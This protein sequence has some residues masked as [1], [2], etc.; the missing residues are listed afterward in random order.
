[1]KHMSYN[2]GVFLYEDSAD[3]VHVS[4]YDD[5]IFSLQFWKGNSYGREKEV[6]AEVISDMRANG[7]YRLRK[8]GRDNANSRNV[9]IY[10]M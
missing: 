8:S 9:S 4:E 6:G 1:M 3:T 5:G 10:D 2:L 7:N